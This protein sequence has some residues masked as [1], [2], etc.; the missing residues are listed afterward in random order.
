L[1]IADS[2]NQRIRR[3]GPD[4]MITT[5]AG[6][7][8][9]SLGDGGPATQATLFNPNDV[10]VG[11]DGSLYIADTSAHRVRRVD[12]SGIIRTVAGNGVNGFSGDGGPATQAQIWDPGGIALGTD[13]SLYIADSGNNRVRRIGTDGIITTVAGN[14]LGLFGGDGGL[15]TQAQLSDPERVALG[16]DGSL[17]I[18]DRANLRVRQVSP[19]GIITTVAGSGGV[20]GYGGDGFAATQA[21]LNYPVG[22]AVSSDGSLYIADSQNH[23]VRRVDPNGIITTVAGNGA[24]GNAGNGGSATR[25]QLDLPLGVAV[26]PDGSVLIADEFNA[27]VRRV[28]S[29]FPSASLA[30]LTIPSRDGTEL[31]VFD[32][33]GRHLKTLNALTGAL[34]YQFAYDSAGHLASITDGDGNVTT[35]PHDANGSPTAIVAAFGQQ[36]T[37]AVD[38]DGYLSKVTDPVGNAVQLSVSTQGLLNSLTDARGNLHAFTYDALGRLTKDQEP[39]GSAKTLVRTDT[40]NGYQVSVTTAL[41][42]TTTYAIA[43]LAT[44]VVQR[45]VTYPSGTQAVSL[46]GTDGSTTLTAA[47]GTATTVVL[48]PDPRFGMLAP[49]AASYSVTTPGGVTSST[50]VSRTATLTDPSNPFSLTQQTDTVLVN[51]Q[52]YTRV[53]DAATRTFTMMS[54]TGRNA[55]ASIDTVGRV[56]RVQDGNLAPVAFTYDAHGRLAT[57]TEGSGTSARITTLAYDSAGNLATVTDPLLRVTSVAYDAAGRPIRKTLPDGEVVAFAYDPNGNVTSITPPGRTAHAFAY[58]SV[59]RVASYTPPDVGI[60]NTATGYT[61]NL[62]RRATETTRPDGL[63]ADFVYDSAGRLAT[64]TIPTG[65]LRFAYD[66][67]TGHVAAL[68]TPSEVS[69]GFAHDGSLPTGATWSGP[70]AGSVAVAYDGSFRVASQSLNGTT[71]AFKY[72]QDNLLTQAGSLVL[73]RDASTGLVTGT[74]LGTVSD[75]VGYD[76]FGYPASYSASAGSTLLYT[77]QFTRDNLGRITEK[78]E[79]IGGA[80]DTYA[81]SYDLRGR[82]IQAQKNGATVAT[83]TYDA[84]GNRVSFTG[85]GGT[86]NGTYDAQDRL[87]AYGTTTYA[88]TAN[89]E[90]QSATTSGQTTTYQYDVLGNLLGFSPPSGTQVGYVVDGRNRRVGKK[91]NGILVQGFLYQN[92]LR[93]I[94][95][96]DG[97][98]NVVSR[99]VYSSPF[100]VPDYLVKG[101]N[102]YR[103]IADQLGSPRLVVDAATGAIAQRLDYDAFGNVLQDTNPGFQPFGFGGGLYDKDTKLV[104]FGARDYDPATGR[105]T[106]KDPLRFRGGGANLYGYVLGDPVNQ[107]DV[108]GVGPVEWF[109][110]TV[111]GKLLD[112]W[113]RGKEIDWPTGRPR[114][115]R[116]EQVERQ[117][118]PKQLEAPKPDCP[119]DPEEEE[120]A[121][122]APEEADNEVSRRIIADIDWDVAYRSDE[123]RYYPVH[124]ATPGS[125]WGWGVI[126]AT[127][128]I[129]V[130]EGVKWG[131]AVIL[132]PET[133]GGSLAGAAALP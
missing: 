108:A 107:V 74:S 87:T 7:A 89:G 4:G 54:P 51:G 112:R 49:L 67:K 76:G 96:L 100:G 122:P 81:Y 94:A 19:S 132:A 9:G 115:T 8:F 97:N 61:Y 103:I 37:L 85:P 6:G 42:R 5:V 3:V 131:G 62:D 48:G 83:Y 104:R 39:D 1:Y 28:R 31:Y 32:G 40:P 41:G 29:S 60:G 64:L 52:T 84:N 109:R 111:I 2:A 91:V 23:R 127:V 45:T 11:L 78:T 30:Q 130:W 95:E 58:T 53:Y 90:L 101:A 21:Q 36:T 68:S 10:A 59:D 124:M 24:P 110:K 92:G 35:I 55:M 118:P 15:A 47:D 72:D 119:P 57:L 75:S 17:Y 13:G 71:L 69:L 98:N 116:T 77:V 22:I 50:T 117:A 93:P 133:G 102:T 128:A 88:Y 80:I 14:G 73:Q 44:G 66:L 65:Q 114:G 82:L 63:K 20:P 38:S 43:R 46:T 99:F 79:T 70:V 27:E 121:Q 125:G 123:L 25:A 86:A 129:G 106:T 16:P 26:T 126:F 120:A 105:W 12:P 113:I 18:A 34:R 56:A 33:G